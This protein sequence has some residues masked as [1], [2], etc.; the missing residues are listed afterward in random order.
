MFRVFPSDARLNG[1]SYQRVLKGYSLY[2]L[3]V[4]RLSSSP[5]CRLSLPMTTRLIH[6]LNLFRLHKEAQTSEL[7]WSTL[8]QEHCWL[9]SG[10]TAVSHTPGDSCARTHPSCLSVTR[11]CWWDSQSC[12]SVIVSCLRE[13]VLLCRF[14][15]AGSVRLIWLCK[16]KFHGVSLKTICKPDPYLHF[17]DLNTPD[18]F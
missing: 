8:F 3:P 16:L 11:T 5:L 6:M 1:S 10:G 17:T 2:R 18:L 15:P 9:C 7:C 12:G 4:L 14:T 13:S